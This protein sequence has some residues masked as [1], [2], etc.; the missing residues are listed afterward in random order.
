M[1]RGG[2][3]LAGLR[4]Q[5]SSAQAPSQQPLGGSVSPLAAQY[6]QWTLGRTIQSTALPRDPVEFLTGAFGPLTPIQPV[7]IDT[8]PP[9][10]ERPEPRRWQYPVGWNMPVGMPGTEG[11]KLADFQT[12]R[13][14]SDIYSVARACIQLRKDEMLGIGWDIGPTADAAKAMRGDPAALQDSAKRRAEAIKFFSRPDTNYNDF[15]SWFEACMEE[16]FV[17]DALS[18]YMHPARLKGKG[19]FGTDLA[20]LDLLDGSSVRPLLDL[21][22]GSP[23]PPNPAY[24]IYQYGI[25]RV[26]LMTMLAGQDVKD[27]GKPVEQYRGD[28]LLYLPRNPRTWT[29]YGQSPLER[30]IIPVIT[31]LRKQQYAMDFYLEGCHDSSTSVLAKRGW[32]PFAKLTGSDE[33]ATRAADGSF[34]WQRPT[35]RQQS[36]YD[37]PMVAFKNKMTDL[38]VTP[39]HRMYVRRVQQKAEQSRY[40]D[41]H[42]REA[43][44]FA[45]HPGA[46]FR[47]TLTS[48]WAEGASGEFIIP[49]QVA[50]RAHPARERAATWLASRLHDEW[51][52]SADVNADARAAGIGKNAL[53]WARHTLGVESRF[54]GGRGCWWEMS[55]PRREY[56]PAVAGSYQPQ[57]EVRI[58]MASFC[59]FL[60]MFLSEGWVRKDRDDLFVAQMETSR[61]LEAMGDA[62]DATGLGWNFTPSNQRF[63]VHSHAM[64][65]WMRENCGVYARNKHVPDGFKDLNAECLAALLDG[66][67]MGDGHIGPLGQMNY[68]TTSAQLADDVQEIMQKLSYNAR[69]DSYAP[70]SGRYPDTKGIRP[71]YVV[72]ERLNSDCLVP[73]AIE[74]DYHGYVYCVT[75]PN[76]VVLTRRN[77]LPAWT[78]NSI[79]GVYISPGDLNMTP[80]QI[81]EVQDSL[82]AIAGDQAY[83]HKVIMLPANSKVD[84]Q[85]PPELADQSDEIL[86]TQVCMAYSVMP[87]ELGISPRV[88]AT[89]S[90]GAANQMAKASEDVQQRKALKPDLLWLKN[91]LFDRI[92]QDVCGQQDLEWKWDGLEEDEDEQTLTTLLVA[93]IGAGLASIDEARVEMG[94]QPWGLPITSDPGWAGQMGFTPLGQISPAGAPEPGVAP[95]TLPQPGGPPGGAPGGAPPGGGQQPRPPAATGQPAAGSPM[96]RVPAAGA[97]QQQ[98]SPTPPATGGTPAHA[99]A[100]A[101]ESVVH[102][103][104]VQKAAGTPAHPVPAPDSKYKAVV[105]ELDA[106]RRHLNKGRLITTWEPRHI[107]AVTLSSIAE[108]MAKGLSASQAVDVARALVPQG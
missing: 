54:H 29:P 33:V 77:G 1:P 107:P 75:V 105:S 100:A 78:G 40:Q 8:P 94:R 93:Q 12:L 51:T 37:G 65:R 98:A 64:A 2:A 63:A 72:R 89:Q 39:N 43:S 31:G 76:G 21:R 71:Y 6:G 59:R 53:A 14:Y 24:Q 26:D 17:I 95:P 60:G 32:I 80:N 82:N 55:R 15:T 50:N 18:L 28:Q 11:L 20:G 68:T 108:D 13:T 67:M 25:P 104:P 38:L 16:M 103:Y 66:L 83:K 41:W 73:P 7:G 70:Q 88:S 101:A 56:V 9:D 81:R 44:Y 87:M 106:L 4:A 99:A 22:G 48:R 58:P 5:Q 69:L 74:V 85:K 90:T 91:A 86:M 10:A 84:P 27:L 57:A 102:E 45:G 36:W 23:S 49:A 97:P 19:L 96:P 61:H 3:V 30:C 42:F 62:L 46:R 34:E 52:L 79:P 35:Q 92:I 47:M